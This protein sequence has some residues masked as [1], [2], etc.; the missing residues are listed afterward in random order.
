MFLQ[1]ASFLQYRR[2]RYSRNL[3]RRDEESIA[4][5]YRSNGFRDVAVKS[6]AEDD[7]LGKPATCRSRRYQR[8]PAV[9]RRQLDVEGIAHLDKA[10]DREHASSSE[11]SRS[12]NTMWPWIMTPILNDYFVNG[13]PNASFEWSFAAGRR[14]AQELMFVIRLKKGHSNS[15]GQCSPKGFERHPAAPGGYAPAA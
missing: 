13:F 15:C 4:N 8:R 12:A 2:G 5:L 9:F 1:P 6:R 14:A 10:A 7:Y 11:V 3:L